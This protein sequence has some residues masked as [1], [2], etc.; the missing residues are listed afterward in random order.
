MRTT[1]RLI[2]LV[3]C[4][5]LLLGATVTVAAA[6][7]IT[8]LG[9][10]V[11]AE[12]TTLTFEKVTPKEASE[13]SKEL[14]EKTSVRKIVLYHPHMSVEQLLALRQSVPQI[15]FTFQIRWNAMEIDTDA[16]TMDLGTQHNL[17]LS[18]LKQVWNLMPYLQE[19]R[20]Y[21]M[22]LSIRRM[23][24]LMA[25]Y[26]T[27]KFKWMVPVDKVYYRDDSTAL[28]TKHSSGSN[29]LDSE[30]FQILRYLPGLRAIDL[31]HNKIENLD[32]LDYFPN[33][34]LLVLADNRLT[35]ISELAN[36]PELT[37]LELFMNNI[38]DLSPLAGLTNLQDL[39]LAHNQISDLT[40][41]EGLKQLKRLWISCNNV[42]EE[43]INQLR[44][45][46]PNTQIVSDEFWST[47][48]GWREHKHY[49]EMVKMFSLHIYT[50][51]SS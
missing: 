37:Y 4:L 48:G 16:K 42:T 3:L 41:L 19:V 26:P 23:E 43:Q 36:Y 9:Q 27:V 7:A 5:T 51:L 45:A 22:R 39:N 13:L 18:D 28:S 44:K 10:Q 30:Y 29:R 50:P 38:S 33:L 8:V 6:E 11:T 47:G 49:H 35:D 34:S 24:K 40:P 46:L 20:L 1:K 25:E 17:A 32:F 31:G 15:T 21:G 12:T 2:G 14:L